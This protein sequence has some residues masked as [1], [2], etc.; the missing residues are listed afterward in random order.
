MCCLDILEHHQTQRPRQI[1]CH[2]QE[3]LVHEGHVLTTYNLLEAPQPNAIPLGIR[4]LHMSF[5]GM[6]MFSL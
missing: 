5:E 3:R 2:Q 6:Q 4:V 1:C